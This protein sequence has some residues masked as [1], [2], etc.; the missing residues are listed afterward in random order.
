MNVVQHDPAP[1]RNIFVRSD[2]YNFIR[3]GIPAVMIAFGN[4]KGSRE[5][6][7]EQAWLSDRITPPLM[8]SG[9]R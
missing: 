9:S 8:I 2:Q 6:G 7:I 1:L 4:K 5:E 3:R